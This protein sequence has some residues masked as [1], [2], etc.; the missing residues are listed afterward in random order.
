MPMFRFI[1]LFAGIGGFHHALTAPDFGGQC[2]LAVE[3]D[4]KCQQI[5]A[6]T[7]PQMAATGAIAGDIRAMTQA[8]TGADRPLRDVA[9]LVPDHDVLCA[10][11][12]CQPFSKSG[13]QQGVADSTRGTLFFDILRIIEAKR[14]R[15]LILENVRN[16]A[17]PRHAHTWAS[18]VASL[19]AQG[20][21]V[22]DQPVVISPHK[23]SPAE[24]GAPQS[25]ERVFILGTRVDEPGAVLNQQPLVAAEPS[26]DWD[27]NRWNIEDYLLDEA[28]VPHPERYRL[29]PTE[30]AW[31]DAWQDFIRGLP[32]DMLPG[33]PIW[34]DAFTSTPLNHAG[35]PAW[36]K[37][38]LQKN[39]AF[40]NRHRAFID[41]WLARHQVPDFPA[42]RRKLEWQARS[43][44]PTRARRNLWE[45]TIHLRPSGVRV[46][47][48][49]Y[50]P[51]L[52][53][54]TQTSI[55][56]SRR[57][58]ITPVEAGRLQGL[59][60]EVFG[61]GVVDDATAYKQAGNAVNTGVVAHVARA[62]FAS[63]GLGWG[64]D[65]VSVGGGLAPAA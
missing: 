62:L 17:G 20:Y 50:L 38:I 25:R 55:I 42:S 63:A 13:A 51:A 10:G 22:S 21:R 2:V 9:K 14:P 36:K 56:G 53:A 33:F 7:W 48:A 46:K 11:F 44:Q 5:Y 47:P 64:Q 8:P 54:I 6:A 4:P 37:A 34:V 29:R 3:S 35:T 65:A 24:G 52:V 12:P 43:T 30:V 57:R 18:I 45:L 28:D 31:L 39:S 16:L 40:Y 32:D 59:P 27:P 19:H 1:D 15:F 23:L 61:A 60:D 49:T 58:R 41:A 26:P